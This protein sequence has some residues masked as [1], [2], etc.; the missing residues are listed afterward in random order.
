M[1]TA[2]NPCG[3][4]GI[5]FTEFCPS[6][7]AGHDP[8]RLERL[9]LAFGF[10]KLHRHP[11]RDIVHFRQNDIHV[12]PNGEREGHSAE[13]ARAHGPAIG[14]MGWLVDGDENGYLLQIFTRNL[15]GPIF[16][17]IIQRA[18][19]LGFGKGNFGALFRSLEKDQERRGV[20]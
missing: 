2:T 5:A 1:D 14:A 4:R 11:A 20:L 7:T 8:G 12:L 15:I 10:S 19:H 18:E 17:E 6:T 13:F 3:I 9:F 16:I